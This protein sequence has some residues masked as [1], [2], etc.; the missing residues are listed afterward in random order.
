MAEARNEPSMEEILASIKRIIS[1]DASPARVVAAGR[2][3]GGRPVAVTLVNDQDDAAAGEVLELTDAVGAP[4]EPA[5][6]PETPTHS[7]LE[8]AVNVAPAAELISPDVAEASRK[9][10][11]ALSGLVIAPA[12]GVDNTLDG[13]VRE[14]LR[15]M[16]K[17][18]LDARLPELVEG[19]VAREISR[20]T[21][22][23]L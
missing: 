1:D 2:A 9:A 21:G 7:T 8:P 5:A 17:E 6:P 13:L 3:R 10:L 18:W 20:I 22:R 11:E 12:P 4:E 15:P 14:M 19:L 23:S 16:L